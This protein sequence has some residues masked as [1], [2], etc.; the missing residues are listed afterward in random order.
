[1]AAGIEEI[2]TRLA[3]Q[4]GLAVAR[5]G[6]RLKVSPRRSIGA[7]GPLRL[8]WPAAQGRIAGSPA[9]PRISVSPDGWAWLVWIVLVGA[10]T[11]EVL[12]DR[13]DYPREYPVWAPFA[14]L[15][16]YTLLM[17]GSVIGLSA[18]IRHGLS[19]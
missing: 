15:G 12:M 2:A 11:V 9:A 17:I 1:M 16:V 3:G 6:D 19:R 5:A 10:S 14:A 8:L 7:R 4:R 13:A 18:A